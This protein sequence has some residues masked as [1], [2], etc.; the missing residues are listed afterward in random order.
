MSIKYPPWRATDCMQS[1]NIH[2]IARLDHVSFIAAVTVVLFHTYITVGPSSA[3]QD[4]FSIPLIQQGHTG[5]QLFMVISGII[6][7]LIAGD[8]EI[9]VSKFYLNRVLRIY[10]LYVFIVTL[11]Y[12]STPDPRPTSVGVDYLMSL[13][14]IS[15]LYRLQYGEWGAQL[16]TVAVELQFYLLFPFLLV[17]MRKYGIG[18]ILGLI[19]LMIFLR[20]AI[21]FGFTGTVHML[22]FFSIFGNLE[23]FLAG[24]L[25]GDFYRTLSKQG[26]WWYRSWVLPVYF[27]GINLVI[28]ALFKN[29]TFF[30]VDFYGISTDGVSH[31]A[32][33]ILWPIFQAVMWAGFVVIYL[34]SDLPIPFSNLFATFGKYSYS[35]YVWHMFILFGL[36][37]YVHYFLWL[38]PFALGVAVVLPITIALSA[39]SYYLIERPFLEMRVIYT[40]TKA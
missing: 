23:M 20:A 34:K 12:F 18:Y 7:T 37:N 10:P 19:G 28:Y 21:Q 8:K 39:A 4:Y 5:V 31:S 33:W 38:S 36:K 3:V 14:P 32:F 2:Y 6:L 9:V 24:M 27:L 35:I 26:M 17:F 22:A 11:G 40:K 29:R 16:W 25:A 1:K 15:N 30:H 13:L